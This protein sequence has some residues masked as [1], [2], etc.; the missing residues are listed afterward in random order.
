MTMNGLS[1]EI[2]TK[3]QMLIEFEK[4]IVDLF[5]DAKIPYPIHLSGG[6]ERQLIDIFQE[7]HQGDYIFATHRNHY[8]YLLAGGNPDHLERMILNGKSMHVYDN[9]LNFFTSAIVAGCPG[10]AAGVAMG[11]KQQNSRK[12]VWCFIGDGAED[13]GHFYEA[14]RYV[15]GHDLPCTFIIEDNDRSVE[16]PKNRRYG[17][18]SLQWPDCVRRY[19]YTPTYPHVGTGTGNL[20]KFE[21][22]P[23]DSNSF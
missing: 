2:Q 20:I 8:H 19:H 16:T 15:D 5:E 6:N 10:L 22:R 7:I 11:L 18:S 4:R 21:D 14:V 1:Q 3:V 9:E 17:H 23:I 13:E 12:R